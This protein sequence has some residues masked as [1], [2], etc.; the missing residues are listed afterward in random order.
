MD[1]SPESAA[2]RDAFGAPPIAAFMNTA[3]D[4]DR[5]RNGDPDGFAALWRRIRP[6]LEVHL[7]ARLLPSVA[8]AIRVHVDSEDL[9]QDTA[10]VAWTRLNVFEYRGP[11]SLLAWLR[12]ILTHLFQDRLD[13]WRAGKRHPRATQPI[14]SAGTTS[15]VAIPI[16][17]EGPGPSTSF[18]MAE[19]RRRV[20]LALAS[21]PERWYTMLHLRFMGGADWNEVAEAIGAMSPDAA[22][23]ECTSRALPAFAQ[24]FARARVPPEPGR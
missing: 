24:A 1:A 17:D 8:P 20:S 21:L 15:G 14:A 7:H 22:R 2:D 10:M 16:A 9:L 18:S 4:L 19:R 23:V 13:Y 5:H 11:G 12:E 6:A 3:A